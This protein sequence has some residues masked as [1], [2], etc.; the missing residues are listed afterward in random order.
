MNNYITSSHL[1]SLIKGISWRIIATSDT[2][3]V[4]LTV[5]CL[6][7]NC[8]IENAIKI[9]VSEFLIKLVLYFIHE[10]IWIKSLGKL[11]NSYKELIAKTFTWRIIATITTF[12]ISGIVIN[13][14]GE[15]ALAIALV[16]LISK[17]ILYFIHEKVWLRFSFGKLQKI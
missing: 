14:F 4:V 7:G 9:S 16:E 12:V 13:S 8:S 10:R 11:A 3:L 6:F 17:L 1:R 2:F 15:I 5:T